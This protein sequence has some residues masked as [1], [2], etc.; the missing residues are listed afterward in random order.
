MRGTRRKG[1]GRRWEGERSGG[2]EES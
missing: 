1:A 2:E